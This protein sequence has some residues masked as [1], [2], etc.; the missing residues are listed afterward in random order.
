MEL[1]LD[2][3]SNFIE[4]HEVERAFQLRKILLESVLNY[5][6]QY[7]RHNL[8]GENML[9]GPRHPVDREGCYG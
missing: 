1:H 3:L 6:G 5:S 2:V 7:Y 8:V 4:N 9:H